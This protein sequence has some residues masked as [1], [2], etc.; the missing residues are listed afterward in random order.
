MISLATKVEEQRN[1][2]GNVIEM[3]LMTVCTGPKVIRTGDR[4]LSTGE[5]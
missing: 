1:E 4:N 5:S 3:T 2:Q